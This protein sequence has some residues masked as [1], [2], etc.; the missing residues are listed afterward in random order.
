MQNSGL[1][2]ALDALIGL[3]CLYKQ[4]LVLV[5]SNRGELEW[6]EIQHQDWGKLT[7]PLLEVSGFTVFDV[8]KDGIS[9]ISQAAQKAEMAREVAILLLHRGNLDE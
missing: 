9:A 1:G 8:E 7:L 6:E 4:G 3:F 5:V 2:L